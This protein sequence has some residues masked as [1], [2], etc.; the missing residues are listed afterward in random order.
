MYY[1]LKLL[2]TIIY[3]GGILRGQNYLLCLVIFHVELITLTQRKMPCQKFLSRNWP[4]HFSGKKSKQTFLCII[5]GVVSCDCHSGVCNQFEEQ[6]IR[7]GT[8]RLCSWLIKTT[9]DNKT[10][11]VD[12]LKNESIW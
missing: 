1:D 5:D 11:E 2:L 3:T 4:L 10:I 12:F 7:V 9:K 6:V 8:Y